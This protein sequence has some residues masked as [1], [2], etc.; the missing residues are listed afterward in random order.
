MNLKLAFL[1]MLLASTNVATATDNIKLLSMAQLTSGSPDFLYAKSLLNTHW[2]K[3]GKFEYTLPE[4]AKEAQAIAKE[5]SPTDEW[6]E[7]WRKQLPKDEEGIVYGESVHRNEF[8]IDGGLFWSKDNRKLAFYRM[9]ESM[10]QSYHWFRQMTVKQRYVGA[11]TR[12]Q[13]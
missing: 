13:A 8:G 1:A 5:K 2:N 11:S 10:V 6:E 7:I 9:D 3:E 12:W 4:D